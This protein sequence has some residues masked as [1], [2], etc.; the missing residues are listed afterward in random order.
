MSETKETSVQVRLTKADRKRIEKVAQ[1]FYL[2]TSAWVRMT[3]LRA[4][5]A[6]ELANEG[7]TTHDPDLG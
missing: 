2:D 3:V 6:W 5:D 4:V 7:S 1:A